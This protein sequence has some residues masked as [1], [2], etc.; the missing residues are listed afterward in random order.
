MCIRDSVYVS[1]H[2]THKIG[3]T[4]IRLQ[5][6]WSVATQGESALP[7]QVPSDCLYELDVERSETP[8]SP[9][10]DRRKKIKNL[11]AVRRPR[12]R[13]P[14]GREVLGGELWIGYTHVP[15]RI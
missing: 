3:E 11:V 12:I 13:V 14:K 7:T 8:R 4:P 15:N 6:A 10:V 5:P 2:P 9:R 1:T